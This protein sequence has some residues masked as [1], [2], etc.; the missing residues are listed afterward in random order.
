M[1]RNLD[2]L[3]RIKPRAKTARK[4]F[5][6]PEGLEQQIDQA[7]YV[8][9]DIELTGLDQKKDSIVAF[10]GIRMHGGKII[11]E[12]SFY[13]L[14]RPKPELAHKSVTIHGLTPSDLSSKPEINEVLPRFLKFCGN[15]VLV[16]FLPLIDIE[17]INREMNRIYG[18]MLGNPI[19]DVFIAHKWINQ[20]QGFSN[21]VTPSL[22]DIAESHEIPARQAHN[23]LADA[24]ITAQVFQHIIPQLMLQGIRNIRELVAVTTISAKNDRFRYSSKMDNL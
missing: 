4:Y 8:V 16:G 6:E 1:I 3:R 12:D 20:R 18:R 15:D 24:F 9:I 14:V 13:E 7:D 5:S 11:L 19:V 10:G 21:T 2:W 17:F 22:Y 23:A